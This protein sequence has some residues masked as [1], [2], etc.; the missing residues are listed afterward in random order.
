[1]A[2][3]ELNELTAL[4]LLRLADNPMGNAS[5]FL[6]E[7]IVNRH[8]L[9]RDVSLHEFLWLAHLAMTGGLVKQALEELSPDDIISLWAAKSGHKKQRGRHRDLIYILAAC[10]KSAMPHKKPMAI[11]SELVLPLLIERGDIATDDVG[12]PDPYQEKEARKNFLK[13]MQRA[14]RMSP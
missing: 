4:E 14:R 7:R 2:L 6:A 9:H 8:P 3:P 1:M 10:A 12:Q 11:Y 13:A 5:M